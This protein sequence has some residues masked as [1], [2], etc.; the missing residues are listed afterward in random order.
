VP[1]LQ[2]KQQ[3]RRFETPLQTRSVILT[4]ERLVGGDVKVIDEYT[5]QRVGRQQGGISSRSDLVVRRDVRMLWLASIGGALIFYDFIVFAFFTPIIGK[6]FFPPTAGGWVVGISSFGIFAAGY[7]FRP[8][9]GVILAHFGDLFGRKRIFAFSILVMSFSTLGISILPAYNQIGI[10]APFMLI[11]FRILQGIAIGGEVPGAWTFVVEHLPRRRAGL[12]CGSVSAGLTF[13][14]LLGSIVTSTLYAVFPSSEMEAFAW[15]IPFILGALFSVPAIYARRWLVETPVFFSMV[16]NKAL[17]P[18]VPLKTVLGNY[19][20]NV[21]ISM[22]LTWILATCIVV[23]SLMTPT[24]L[25]TVY[26]WSSHD[27]LGAA[28]LGTLCAVLATAAAGAIIDRFGAANCLAGGSLAFGAATFAFYTHAGQSVAFLYTLYAVM[29]TTMG[30]IATVPYIMALIFPACVR[31]TGISFS[32][33]IAYAICGGITPVPL[34]LAMEFNRMSIAYHLLFIS[35]LAFCLAVYLW[36]HPEIFANTSHR[37]G[38][39]TG[40]LESEPRQAD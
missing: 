1:L 10:A 32:Y 4:G 5:D 37:L 33:N 16:A 31:M 22:L 24:L 17:V 13:G 6:L 18:E 25:Q 38:Q 34:A 35:G 15:R 28:T 23:T 20:R 21:V 19:P 29:G 11:V 3:R 30:F 12:A 36:R 26:G 7:L 8:L 9:G 27:A 14:I 39:M 40:A 2:L